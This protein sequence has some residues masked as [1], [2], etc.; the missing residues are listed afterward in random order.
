MHFRSK[1]KS[2]VVVASALTRTTFDCGQYGSA[3][4]VTVADTAALRRPSAIPVA[5]YLPSPAVVVHTN[6]HLKPPSTDAPEIGAPVTASRTCP[7]AEPVCLRRSVT[8]TVVVASAD[9]V[10]GTWVE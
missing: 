1:S 5:E 4:A 6:E 10:A 8:S 2:V 7:V 3:D 9:S